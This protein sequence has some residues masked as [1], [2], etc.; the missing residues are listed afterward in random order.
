MTANM[1]RKM[2]TSSITTVSVDSFFISILI[3]NFLLFFH[4]VIIDYPGI[5]DVYIHFREPVFFMNSY[6]GGK[7]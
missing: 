6:L 1:K 3:M 2:N 4:C 5:C 7:Q